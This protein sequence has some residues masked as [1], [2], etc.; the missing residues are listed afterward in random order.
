MPNAFIIDYYAL[1]LHPDCYDLL[2]DLIDLELGLSGSPK[3]RYILGF[4]LEGWTHREIADHLGIHHSTVSKH[5][6]KVRTLMLKGDID[7][8]RYPGSF[9]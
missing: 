3:S 5:I 2:I 1:G 4:V 7:R 9:R 6:K 8:H